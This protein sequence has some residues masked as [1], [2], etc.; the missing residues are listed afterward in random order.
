[1]KEEGGRKEQHI[2]YMKKGRFKV[3][4]MQTFIYKHTTDLKN[5]QRHLNYTMGPHA[6]IAMGTMQ[7]VNTIRSI[8]EMCAHTLGEAYNSRIS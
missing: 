8:N 5:V 1:L 6:F 7:K 3:K 4:I 2:G